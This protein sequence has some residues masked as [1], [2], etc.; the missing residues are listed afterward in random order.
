MPSSTKPKTKP[1]RRGVEY[2]RVSARGDRDGDK[3]KSPGFQHDRIAGL[4]QGK[5]IK[6]VESHQD[7][8]ES[9][10]KWERPGFQAA[11]SAVKEGRADVILV[12]KMSRFARNVLAAEK[13]LKEIE[14]AG[15]QLI[16][17]DLDV[18]TS[19]SQGKLMRRILSAFA[20]FELEVHKEQWE[21]AKKAAHGN[22]VKL[23]G[24]APIGYQWVNGE[25]KRLTPNP[26][27]SKLIPKVFKLRAAGTSWTEIVKW[28]QRETGELRDRTTFADMI[29]NRTYV[30]EVVYA[31]KQ[32]DWVKEGAHKALVTEEQW[33]A[34]Q[35]VKA[36]RSARRQGSL[37][38][39]V[40]VCGTCGGKLVSGSSGKGGKP[41]YRCPNYGTKCS[42]PASV[43]HEVVNPYVED[44]F[45]KWAKKK[46]EVE[47]NAASAKRLEAAL[48]ALEDARA[49]YQAFALQVSASD[50]PDLL[51]AGLQQR[52]AAILEAEEKVEEIRSTEK[53][54][55]LRTSIVKDWR[56]GRLS[57]EEQRQLLHAAEARVVI[58]PSGPFRSA[59]WLPIEDRAEV[60]FEG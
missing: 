37:L 7:I 38:A 11:L 30:G 5:N 8:D 33:Q 39:G 45:L 48:T 34:A 9:G 3:L 22:G 29:R 6:V 23:G 49:E 60:S 40:L 50:Y 26:T 1:L 21:E 19:T 42:A 53:T 25:D 36:P 12:S 14:E 32:G 57:L 58:Q 31:H 59:S 46:V 10:G 17:G 47:G 44:A 54:E 18:D 16:C 52:Q 28:W 35:G 27:Y 20:E 15:G 55:R 43:S 41:R 2:I 24:R 56:S 13:A 51:E 4:A